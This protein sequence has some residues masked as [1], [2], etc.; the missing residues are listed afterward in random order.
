MN[1]LD[2]IAARQR[3]SRLRD[4]AFAALV[5]VVGA[6]SIST[7]STAVRASDAQVAHR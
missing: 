6:A 7:V 5:V 1:R 2:N 4:L 3:R